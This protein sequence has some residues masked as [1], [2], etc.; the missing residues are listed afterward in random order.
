MVQEPVI[1]E[2]R[3]ISGRGLFIIEGEWVTARRYWLYA[4]LLREPKPDYKNNKFPRQKGNYANMLWLEREYVCREETM[5][6]ELQRWDWYGDVT[7]QVQVNQQCIADREALN[8]QNAV[9]A[10]EGALFIIPGDTVAPMRAGYDKIVVECRDGCAVSFELWAQRY[11]YCPNR[12]FTPP[13]PPEPPP[14]EEPPF[15]PGTPFDGKD[16]RPFISPPYDGE[17]DGG[18]TVP[19]EGDEGVEPPPEIPSCTLLDLIVSYDRLLDGVRTRQSFNLQ[20]YAPVGAVEVRE[21]G[22]GL[23]SIFLFSAGSVPVGG[24]PNPAQCI[25]PGFYR[26]NRGV[27]VWSNP[28]YTITR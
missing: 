6:Y 3:I 24:A 13:P 23:S 18:D 11:D 12:D 28:S 8:L 4:R 14:Q 1:I 19:D 10:L 26:V 20:A 9:T 22:G 5:E 27:G 16:G 17:I 15:S 2:E 25:I 7:G 21:V